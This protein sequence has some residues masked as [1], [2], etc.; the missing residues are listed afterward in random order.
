M[1]DERAS[2]IFASKSQAVYQNTNNDKQT[3][4]LMIISVYNYDV[5]YKYVTAVDKGIAG[6]LGTVKGKDSPWY[7]NQNKV[8]FRMWWKGHRHVHD[9]RIK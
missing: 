9:L 8:I 7:L 2:C 1:V 6:D 5:F 4:M 3:G